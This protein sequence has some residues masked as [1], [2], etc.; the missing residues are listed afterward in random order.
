MILGHSHL[1]SKCKTK[2]RNF[3]S[4]TLHSIVNRAQ[5][6]KNEFWIEMALST[7][8]KFEIIQLFERQYILKDSWII[9]IENMNQSDSQNK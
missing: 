1:P 4:I 2:T 5:N 8:E 7:L 6:A 3:L 9:Q